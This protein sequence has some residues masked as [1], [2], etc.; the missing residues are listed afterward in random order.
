MIKKIYHRITCYLPVVMVVY[1]DHTIANKNWWGHKT[2]CLRVKTKKGFRK[3]TA[4]VRGIN[5]GGKMKKNQAEKWFKE[6]ERTGNWDS[7]FPEKTGTLE[8]GTVTVHEFS[9]G[10][11][12]LMGH[13][14]V[15]TR[16]EYESL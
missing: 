3:L 4:L 2:A 14:T 10:S 16:E 15:W 7:G 6:A 13:G 8:E 5:K 9:D 11:E 12:I 1:M